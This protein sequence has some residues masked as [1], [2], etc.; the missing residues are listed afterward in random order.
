M[1]T[2]IQLQHYTDPIL[3]LVNM[4]FFLATKETKPWPNRLLVCTLKKKWILDFKILSNLYFE[5]YF[6]MI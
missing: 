4:S 1:Y 3:F 5:Y 6:N 2:Y